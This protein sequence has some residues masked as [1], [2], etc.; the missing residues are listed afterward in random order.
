[1]LQMQ[2]QQQHHQPPPPPPPPG[3][4][5]SAHYAASQMAHVNETV[6]LQIGSFANLLQAPEE[7]T[8][9]Y[10]RALQANPNS[11]AAMSA[12][13][14]ILKGREL[15]DKALEFFRAI[16]QIDQTNGEAWGNL[17][18]RSSPTES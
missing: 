7:A 9:A 10:E 3:H 16:V 8:Q 2:H 15:Y 1:M 4:Q 6:W 18:M 5:Q 13:G 14:M 17:G 11:T 12:I